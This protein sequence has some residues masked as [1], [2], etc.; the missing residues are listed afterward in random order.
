MGNFYEDYGKRYRA[1]KDEERKA[2]ARRHWLRI[3]R[4]NTE[5]GRE[6]LIL[7]SAQMLEAMGIVPQGAWCADII[8]TDGAD[9]PEYP[10]SGVFY[11]ANGLEVKCFGADW[12]AFCDDVAS[13]T[14][15]IRLP[16]RKEMRFY[17]LSDREQIAGIDAAHERPEGIQV[18]MQERIVKGWYAS[19]VLFG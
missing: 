4:E 6:D 11:F 17:K 2:A 15:G 12:K 13:K 3:H 14:W 10:Y 18:S 19:N 9:F 1:C 7:F 5:K 8:H 16:Q